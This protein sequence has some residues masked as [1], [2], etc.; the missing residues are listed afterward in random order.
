MSTGLAFPLAIDTAKGDLVLFYGAKLYESHI[1]TWLLT[2]PK[3]RVMR[4][5]YGLKDFLFD[6]VSSTSEIIQVIKSG[7]KIYVPNVT[8]NEVATEVTESGIIISIYWS[9]KDIEQEMIKVSY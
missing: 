6:A 7:L 3:E 9:F 5:K 8:I 2:V 4:L 1:L